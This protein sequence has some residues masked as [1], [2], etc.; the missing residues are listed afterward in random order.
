MQKRTWITLVCLLV[1][2]MLFAACGGTKE[3]NA[4]PPESKTSEPPIPDPTATPA[5]I[6][7]YDTTG[8]NIELLNNK[9]GTKLK[10]KFPNFTF[11]IVPKVD[12]NT[13]P[14]LISTGTTVDIVVES[15]GVATFEF[16][17][18]GDISDLITKYK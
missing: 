7:I 15:T 12:N 2:T 3:Q 13:L 4:A 11:Q 18:Q 9:Y 8:E 5:N 17:L 10:E 6:V 1:F 16:D 14:N